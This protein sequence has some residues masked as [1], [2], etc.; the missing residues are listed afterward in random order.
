MKDRVFEL[1]D[2]VRETGYAIHCYHGPGHLE[3]VYE[4]ALVHRL[5]KQ[6]LSVEQ[7]KPL[8]VFDEDGTVLG[9][10]IADIVIEG[11]LILEIKAAKGIADE[12][13]AQTLGYL[14]SARL[15]HGA[16]I[17]FGA[18]KFQI[19]KLVMS[20]VLHRPD[21]DGLPPFLALLFASFCVFFGYFS[22]S[23][24]CLAAV[25][26]VSREVDLCGSWQFEGDPEDVG[27]RDKWYE[28]GQQFK[29]QI[30]VPGAWNTQG[31][32]FDT[33][34]QLQQYL[35]KPV[36]EKLRGPGTESDRL[37]HVYPGPGWYRRVVRVPESWRG[38]TVWLKFGGV[39]RNADIWIGGR[40]VGTHIGYV[41]PFE[42]DV[43][44]FVTPG[45]DATITLRVDARRDRDTDPLMGCMDTLDFLYLTWGGVHRKVSLEATEDTW[46]DDVFVVPHISSEEAE[47]RV[48]PGHTGDAARRPLRVR[49]EVLDS[50]ERSLAVGERPLSADSA[51][52]VTLK[53]S[54]A[55]LWSPSQPYLYTARVTLLE[56]E[57]PLDEKRVRFGMREFQVEGGK[58]LLNGRPI[59]LRGYGDD[60]IYPNT[61][62]PPVDQ[63]EYRRRFRIVKDFGFNYARHHS[64]TP[65]Q[66]YLDVADEMGIMLQPEFPIAYRWD[67]ASKPETKALYLKLWQEVIRRNR[68]HPSIVVWCMGNELY[69]SFELAPQMY[70]LAKELDPT[71][72]VIDSDGVSRKPRPTLDLGVWQ[73]NESAS[74]GYKDSK[75][76][77][78]P[79]SQP[80]VA[81]EMGYFVTLPDLRQINLFQEG[82]RPY[83][84]RDARDNARKAGVED[85]YAQWVDRSNRLQAAC[86][87]TNIEAARRSNLQGYHVWLFQDYPWCAEGV[88]DM[89]YRPK[90][91]TGEEF[92]KFNAPTV[93]LIAQ[94]RRNYRFGEKAEFPLYVS[95]YEQE[96]TQGATLR[97]ELLGKDE[98]LASGSQEG[99]AIPS[100]EVR[101]LTTI[102]FEI[103]QRPRAEQLR[104]VVR[105]E[106]QHGTVTNDWKIWCFPAERLVSDKLTVAG[107]EWLHRQYPGSTRSQP[108]LLVTDRWE[109][110]VSDRLAAGG[111][112][113]LLNPEPLFPTAATRYRPSGWDPGDPAGHVGTIFDPQHP[114]MK[115]MPSEGW[116]DL[117]FYDLVQ[118]GKAILL[119]QT[120]V[121]AEP[122]VR[123]IDTPQRLTRKALLFETSIGPGRLLV[124]GFNFSSAVPAGDPAAV[125]FL[126]ELIRYSLGDEFQSRESVPPA[127]REPLAASPYNP[128][129]K[130]LVLIYT[131]T[132]FQFS[133]DKGKHHLVGTMTEEEKKRVELQARRFFERDVPELTGGHQR[134]VV[135]IRQPQRVLTRLDEAYWPGPDITVPDVEP[136]FD[137]VVVIWKAD[138][139][140]QVTGGPINVADAGGLTQPMGTGQTYCAI[141]S[142]YIS[143]GDR[144]VFKHEWGHSILFYFDAAG[145]TPAP[146]VD[147]HINDTD[148][149]YVHW[150]TATPYILKDE[151][152][153]V[154]IPNSIY[155]NRQGFTHD[156][157]IGRTAAAGKPQDRLGITPEAWA[158][159]G[160][161]TKP[162]PKAGK[163]GQ[164]SSSQH[165]D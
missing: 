1:T 92:R 19:R 56:G 37:F 114:A 70:R 64:W 55:K 65:V 141:P 102:S 26:Q 14:R 42:Y 157:Y 146:A 100:G 93:L 125:Y 51:D 5:R 61:I 132:D 32:E 109:P 154:P 30:Q 90:A 13:V 86:L 45:R 41:V 165:E 156:Y 66:E 80:V 118:G 4:N 153:D 140:D 73:F 44:R 133:N 79:A 155:N 60:C 127:D 112:V 85:V 31:V 78:D 43:T 62:A 81:H 91:V 74:C 99:L 18:P 95:R 138:G 144:N 111:R 53:L 97:W 59:F 69:D 128:P 115:S 123:M 158:S 47:V 145:K 161:V 148:T 82:L 6:G 46:I 17:N 98:R 113:L 110:T 116:C 108:G 25:S 121:T 105:L 49:A 149:R 57:N 16:V 96:A 136:S 72:P 38:K 152:D 71:R 143:A 20:E 117:Q 147:N 122:I 103:P 52:A 104:L 12:H 160:P 67:L 88:V 142:E 36:E 163:S 3:K 124:S 159:G 24:S 9:E 126:D 63:E 75:Y 21:R 150:P 22:S 40:H 2:I 29:R 27:V 33:K 48:T 135:M 119:D 87:K 15:E 77:F 35:A 76:R 134:P 58:F 89:F 34:E 84:L 107:S 137:S 131:K 54:G 23:P 106:D 68:N 129:W 130:I 94:D 8:T 120:R 11:Q 164:G 10:Y 101:Q 50:Q 7:Q 39:H 162:A 151:T 28:D 139:T 83:W